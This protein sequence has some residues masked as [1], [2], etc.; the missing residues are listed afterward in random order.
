VSR[1]GTIL[2]FAHHEGRLAWREWW[3]L[4]SGRRRSARKL[5]LGVIAVALFLHGFAYLFVYRNAELAR[6]PDKRMLVVLTGVLALYGSLMLSQAI[7]SVTRAFYAR[8]DLD[9]IL[10]APVA[11]WRLFAVRIGAITAPIA[12]TSLALAAPFIDI[13]TWL[14]GWHWL[15]AYGVIAAL[16]MVAVAVAVMLT[17][18]LFRL[19]GPRRTRFCAQIVAAVIGASFTIGVQLA[20]ILSYGT[21][22]RFALL[23]SEAVARYAPDSSSM[24]FWP[25][26]AVLGDL[27][28]L[29]VVCGIGAIV[30]GATIGVFAPRFGQLALATAGMAQSPARR[31]RRF[32]GFRRTSPM[33]ALRGKEWTLL[34]R[35]PWL[36]SQSLMQLLYLVPPAFLLRHAFYAGSRTSAL[37]APILIMAAGQLAGGL[38]WLAV[39]GEDAPDLIASAP[40]TSAGVLRAKTEAVTAVLAIVFGPFLVALAFLAPA[41]ALASAL[42][43]AAAAASATAIQFRFRV[44]AKRSQLRRRQTSSRIA[45]FAEALSSC[46][47][48]GAGALAAA[49]SSLAVIPGLFAFAIVVGACRIS[50]AERTRRQALPARRAPAAAASRRTATGSGG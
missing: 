43:I 24:L 22:S 15:A 26:R 31:V 14:R 2:W 46:S 17:V 3:W 40:V 33:R 34:R 32:T 36:V 5:A 8:G 18:A 1:A 12:A 10:S 42:G 49:G 38:A 30:L 45:T 37:L 44:Q 13:L 28:A 39:S 6:P 35:D 11:A 19:I 23:Q 4:L 50:P 21:P 27:S 7:E 29:A 25:A 9:L 47:W 48:A 16:A 20:A 41:A